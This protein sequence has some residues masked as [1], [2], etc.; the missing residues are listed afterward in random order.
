MACFHEHPNGA[1]CLIFELVLVM[2]GLR[3]VIK[4]QLKHLSFWRIPPALIMSANHIR[5]IAAVMKLRVQLTSFTEDGQVS[6]TEF[7]HSMS[8]GHMS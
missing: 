5:V 3:E 7:L 8:R 2:L 6:S 1:L 4:V